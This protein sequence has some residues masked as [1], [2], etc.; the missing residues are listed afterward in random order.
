M[1]DFLKE[2]LRLAEQWINPDP[3]DE[4]DIYDALVA[5]R[6]L[7]AHRL[8]EAGVGSERVREHVRAGQYQ[9]AICI[10]GNRYPKHTHLSV[11]RNAR[12]E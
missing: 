9:T 1:S 5:N 8:V 10:L 6:F 2:M 3:P 12:A 7:E 11:L 4:D